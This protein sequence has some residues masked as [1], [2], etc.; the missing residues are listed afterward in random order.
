MKRVLEDPSAGG[1]RGRGWALIRRQLRRA[2]RQFAVGGV[3]TLFFAAATVGSS[4]ILGWVTDSVLLPAVR[5]GEIAT[6]TLVGAGLAV[7]GISVV[8]GIGITGRRLGAYAANYRLQARDRVEVTDRYLRLPIEWHRRHPTGQLLSNTNADVESAAFIANPLPMAFGVL[9]MLIATAVL[10]VLTDP[11]LALVGFSAGPAIGVVNFLYQRRMRAAAATAQRLRAEVAEIAHES[12]DAA[13]VVKTLGREDAEVGRFGARSDLLRDR[14]VD[15]GRLRAAFDPVVEALP[16]IAILA[17]LAVGSWRVD[18]GFL[19]AGDLVTFAF[20]FRLVAIPMRVFGWLLGELPRAVVGWNRVE[21]VLNTQQEVDYGRHSLGGRGGAS[22]TAE[23]VGYLYPETSVADLADAEEVI[24]RGAEADRRGVESVTLEV[25]PGKTVALVGPTG[26]GKSTIAQ[27]LVRLFDPERGRIDL[28]GRGLVDLDRDA[29][30]DST[31]LVFQE[32][33]LF[34]DTIRANITLGG[35][36][37]ETEVIR[38]AKI[39]RAHEFITEMPEGYGSHVGERGA[40]LS[41]G[42]RQRIALARALIRRPRLLVLDDATSAVDPAVEADILEGLAELDTTV[43]IV[44]YRRSS[45]VLSDEVIFVED[46]RVIGRGSHEELYAGLPSY[47]AL[48]DAYESEA[49]S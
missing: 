30:A 46:G 9:V 38:A 47:A 37:D 18:Q 20:L 25:T 49:V 11:Y 36:Y 23:E 24:D 32:A 29:L 31:A 1:L 17:I 15:V 40:S 6:S 34:D 33:F 26:S 44:A 14:M 12:F 35:E 39:A 19:S 45:I 48:I 2:P 5:S 41:G 7:F 27:L 28:D 43:V 10:L 13:L 42:Q 3:G 16:N 4:F 21:G 22:A 8:R